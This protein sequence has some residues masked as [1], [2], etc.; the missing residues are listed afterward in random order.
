MFN[1]V[2]IQ[3]MRIHSHENNHKSFSLCFHFHLTFVVVGVNETQSNVFF[4]VVCNHLDWINQ[5]EISGE[6]VET[7]T[8]V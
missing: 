2:K 8:Y 5:N 7:E 6:M 4:H 3:L 1:H